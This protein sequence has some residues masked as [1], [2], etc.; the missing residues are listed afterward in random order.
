MAHLREKFTFCPIGTV[1]FITRLP[2]LLL[3]RP[4][5][6]QFAFQCG[7]QT[8]EHLSEPVRFICAA[9]RNAHLNPIQHGTGERI[10]IAT[11]RHDIQPHQQPQ[12]SRDEHQRTQQAENL[13]LGGG[14]ASG[15]RA[16]DFVF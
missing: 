7:S 6:F 4:A 3:R 14:V 15:G 5:V 11:Q 13:H 10:R 2:H 1:R 12:H 8:V 16:C 9:R